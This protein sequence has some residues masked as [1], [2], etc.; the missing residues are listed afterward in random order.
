MI[1]KKSQ[2]L[3]DSLFTIFEYLFVFLIILHFRSMWLHSANYRIVNTKRL[4]LAIACVGIICCVLKGKIKLKKIKNAAFLSI[5]VMIYLGFHISLNKYSIEEAMYFI[6]LCVTM[7]LYHN[8]CD[9]P[10]TDFY[11]KYSNVV[12]VIAIVSLGFWL[13]GTVLGIL[14]PTRTI[15]TTWISNNSLGL[16]KPVKTYHNLYF[17]AQA[18]GMNKA[19]GIATSLNLVRNT[20]FF[21]EA[22]MFSF[23]LA[24]ALMYELFIKENYSK[25]KCVVYIIAIASSF[26]SLGYIIVLMAVSIK[27]YINRNTGRLKNLMKILLFPMIAIVGIMGITYLVEAKLGSGSGTVRVDDFRAG[28]LAWKDHPLIGNG[29]GNIASYQKYMSSFRRTNLGLSNSLMLILAY[30]GIYIFI[31]YV[32]AFTVAIRTAIKT[33]NLERLVFVLLF[34][35]MLIFTIAPFRALTI[36]VLVEASNMDVDEIKMKMSKEKRNKLDII[37]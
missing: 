35:A 28:F 37:E 22:P 9:N 3:E 32:V 4:V 24:L 27:Y 36:F 11:K 20:G 13:F 21:T 1:I 15:Y 14:H 29:F 30:G 23:V 12:F 10:Y 7:I 16:T 5:V 26:S 2:R 17:E 34:M 25:F 19:L 6:I 18:Y 33:K 31:P 8:I